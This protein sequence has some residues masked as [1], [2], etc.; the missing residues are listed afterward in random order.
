MKNEG[1][2]YSEWEAIEKRFLN[3][4]DIRKEKIKDT[5]LYTDYSTFNQ[6]LREYL[7]GEGNWKNFH[8]LNAN[9]N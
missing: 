2:T 3:Y 4:K 1:F 9:P 8:A 7:V 6:A 5:K